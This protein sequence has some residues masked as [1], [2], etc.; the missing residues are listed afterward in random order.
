MHSGRGA[1][2]P[3]PAPLTSAKLAASCRRPEARRVERL[4][5]P[6]GG[7]SQG[8]KGANGE[9]INFADDELAAQGAC[10]YAATLLALAGTWFF[11]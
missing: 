10:V 9:P 5:K 1:E 6:E 8:E 7:S 2:H 4:D 3:S 11:F